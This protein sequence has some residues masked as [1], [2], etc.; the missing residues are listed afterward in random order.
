[1]V[2]RDGVNLSL[3]VLCAAA[4]ILRDVGVCELLLD[5]GAPADDGESVFLAAASDSY[6][7]LELLCRRGADVNGTNNRRGMPLLHWVLDVQH[8]RARVALLLE[9]GARP[10]Q[11]VGPLEE[12]AL[13]VAVRRFRTQELEPLIAHGAEID[14]E[15]AGGMSAYRHALRRGFAAIVARLAELGCNTELTAADELA[16]A[17]NEGYLERARAALAAAPGL[18]P[19]A[20]PEEA[21][22]LCDLAGRNDSVEAL[23]FLLDAGADLTARGL[24]GGTALHQAAWFAQPQTA[25]LLIERGAALA[26]GLRSTGPW[27]KYCWARALR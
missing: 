14:G 6:E 24:D 20:V 7:C 19:A 9:H 22:L 23:R 12:S 3:P 13:H 18:V 2:E 26:K 21:R 1:V 4:G 17:L 11:R 5:A 16:L 10:E 27:P 25:E 15:T 8:D